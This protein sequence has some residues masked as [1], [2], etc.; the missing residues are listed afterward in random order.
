M[1]MMDINYYVYSNKVAYRSALAFENRH[2]CFDGHEN[3][4]LSSHNIL[5][6]FNL[7]AIM[8]FFNTF[9]F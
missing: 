2:H 4:A 8:M 1:T 6:N 5:F 9:A 3:A 7:R